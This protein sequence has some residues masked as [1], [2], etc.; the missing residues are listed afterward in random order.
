M[1]IPDILKE[2]RPSWIRRVSNSMARGSGVRENFQGQLERFYDL[3]IQA[4]ETGDP[5]WVVPILYDWSAS[6]TQS[7]L[8]EGEKNI[9]TILN[10]M[11]MITYELSRDDLTEQQSM[12]VL[13]AILPVFTFALEKAARY[14]METRV[15]FISNEVA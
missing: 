8:R 11:L 1:N 5:A 14:E 7:D 4:V 6:T 10:R 9:S 15:S 2:I 13:G 12:E 3:L